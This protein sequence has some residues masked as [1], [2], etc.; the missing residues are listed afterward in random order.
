[1][2]K[3]QAYAFMQELYTSFSKKEISPDLHSSFIMF[4][5][6]LY[7]KFIYYLLILLT[8]S[9]KFVN[10]SLPLPNLE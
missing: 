1:M 10:N 9:T 4:S 5:Y 3:K 2:V 7:R 8:E 6:S